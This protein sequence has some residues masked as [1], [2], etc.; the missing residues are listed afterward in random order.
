[1]DQDK[2][3]VI[4]T[5]YSVIGEEGLRKLVDR[6]YDIMDTDSSAR[7]IRAMH[8]TDLTESRDKLFMFLVGRFGGPPVYMEK[9]GSPALRM[10]HA[11]FP[12]NG[13]ARDQW[14]ACM[15]QAMREQLHEPGMIDLLNEFFYMV[16]D[17]MR[18]QVH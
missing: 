16:A 10:R 3:A 6:F 18:N 9:R 1:M 12:I 17:A 7:E 2:L 5:L 13:N 8:P 4:G 11:P 15:G 14:M